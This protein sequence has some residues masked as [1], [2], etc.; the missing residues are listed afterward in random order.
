MTHQEITNTFPE[1]NLRE[2]QESSDLT[3]S[4]A[5]LDLSIFSCSGGFSQSVSALLSGSC[6][7]LIQGRVLVKDVGQ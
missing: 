6:S 4:T 3:L 1:K 7:Q 2:P 5:T